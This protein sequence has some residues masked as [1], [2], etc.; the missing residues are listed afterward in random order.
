MCVCVDHLKRCKT[1]NF[2]CHFTCQ[3]GFSSNL[4][5]QLSVTTILNFQ[6]G[7]SARLTDT[8]QRRHCQFV[9][10]HGLIS[11]AYLQQ[12]YHLSEWPPAKPRT[13][14][15]ICFQFRFCT[16]A[17]I[18]LF[19]YFTIEKAASE[20][21]ESSGKD[22]ERIPSLRFLTSNLPNMPVSFY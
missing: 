5:F 14:T 13:G 18:C 11:H 12:F 4:C 2:R 3:L 21:E 7:G 17:T 9:V 10:I 16:V 19:Y 22:V 6:Q 15:S 8:A 20:L 1:S